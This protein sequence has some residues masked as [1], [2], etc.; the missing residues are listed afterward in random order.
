MTT[1]PLG[2]SKYILK[3]IKIKLF[4][5]QIG[6]QELYSEVKRSLR[7]QMNSA[8]P[9]EDTF[10]IGT[11]LIYS[12]IVFS[13]DQIKYYKQVFSKYDNDVTQLV[14]SVLYE[15]LMRDVKVLCDNYLDDSGDS[16]ILNLNLLALA[17]RL[18]RFDTEFGSTL[19]TE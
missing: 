10:Q 7:Q 9:A 12:L 5:N 13:R 1:R 15:L 11:N 2:Y 6:I 18:D 8:S 14:V 19:G 17:Y 4:K 3:Y 16:T